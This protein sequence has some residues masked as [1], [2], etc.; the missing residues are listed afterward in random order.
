MINN[1]PDKSVNPEKLKKRTKI[2]TV[3]KLSKWN[4]HSWQ[5]FTEIVLQVDLFTVLWFKSVKKHC[6]AKVLLVIWEIKIKKIILTI[7]STNLSKNSFLSSFCP[8]LQTKKQES[9][10][11][12]VSDLVTRNISFFVYS[13]SRSNSKPCRIE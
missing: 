9:G 6:V 2:A 10:F 3:R 5:G 11:Q 13:E 8:F 4:A 7:I 12:Q 1:L